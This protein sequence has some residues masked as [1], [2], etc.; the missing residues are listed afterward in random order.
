[1]LERYPQSHLTMFGGMRR[2]SL[3]ATPRRRRLSGW[4]RDPPP[5]RYAPPM[6][7]WQAID[8]VRVVRRFRDDPIEPEL[9]ARI[10]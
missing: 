8:S 3:T 4:R 9:L 5:T 10:L 1:M 7:T 6:E 2:F